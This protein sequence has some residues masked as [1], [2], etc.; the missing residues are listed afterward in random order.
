MERLA[1]REEMNTPQLWAEKVLQS[2]HDLDIAT[3]GGKEAM[4]MPR[5]DFQTL[6]CFNSD[7]EKYFKQIFVQYTT[8]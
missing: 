8:N 7:T 2:G 3:S 1:V 5:V 4:Y 6:N